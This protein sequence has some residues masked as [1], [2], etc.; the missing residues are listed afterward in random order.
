[1]CV[2][3]EFQSPAA[4]ATTPSIYSSPVNSWCSLCQLTG[5]MATKR[6]F[7]FFLNY[8]VPLC[9]FPISLCIPHTPSLA[10]HCHTHRCPFPLLFQSESSYCTGPPWVA[11]LCSS[12]QNSSFLPSLP[13]HFLALCRLASLWTLITTILLAAKSNGRFSFFIFLDFSAKWDMSFPETLFPWI[14][15]C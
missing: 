3:H 11:R 5:A 7:Y 2:S 12:C 1:M 10:N 6:P 8:A 4:S 9:I 14:S 15:E 13:T